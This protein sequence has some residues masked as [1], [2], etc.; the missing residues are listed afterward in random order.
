MPVILRKLRFLRYVFTRDSA[1]GALARPASFPYGGTIG[2]LER[3]RDI[4]SRLKG[5]L[6]T[7]PLESADQ[8]I[9][10]T[11]RVQAVEEIVGQF[12]VLSSVAQDAKRDDKQL[13]GSGD[14][15]LAHTMLASLAVEAGSDG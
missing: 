12:L 3:R 7:Q 2:W 1:F 15:R 14:N 5:N 13:V 11:L 6:K 9:A 10:C 4:R 8:S